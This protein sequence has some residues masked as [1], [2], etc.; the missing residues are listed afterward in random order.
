M[1][2][3]YLIFNMVT[4]SL[5]ILLK[6]CVLFRET[7]CLD[8]GNKLFCYEEQTTKHFIRSPMPGYA[9]HSHIPAHKK[10]VCTH[11]FFIAI[12]SDEQYFLNEKP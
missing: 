3:N 12:T 10:T 5:R 9:I 8:I 11:G 6:Y 4:L 1:F 2:Y 7:N